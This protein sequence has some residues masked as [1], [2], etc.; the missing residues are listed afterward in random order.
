LWDSFFL[1]IQLRTDLQSA[2]SRQ[3]AKIA[4]LPDI[5]LDMLAQQLQ[6]SFFG[7]MPPSDHI[8]QNSI[9]QGFGDFKSVIV[10]PN[11]CA[12]YHQLDRLLY[13]PSKTARCLNKR[14]AEPWEALLAGGRRRQ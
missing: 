14:L 7:D 3:P 11:G 9:P 10:E 5:L 4:Y 12:I 1:A 6:T 13:I 8:D 2:I